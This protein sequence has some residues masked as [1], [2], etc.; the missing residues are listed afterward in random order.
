MRFNNSN[1]QPNKQAY[2]QKYKQIVEKSMNKMKK[3]DFNNWWFFGWG[4]A[5]GATLMGFILTI[6]LTIMQVVKP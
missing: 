1:F 5:L 4:M 3:P 2:N 6:I